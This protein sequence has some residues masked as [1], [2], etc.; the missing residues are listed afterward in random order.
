MLVRILVILIYMLAMG[1]ARA[2]SDVR[3]GCLPGSAGKTLAEVR[4]QPDAAWHPEN[5]IAPFHRLAKADWCRLR[6]S[7]PGPWGK[8]LRFK[9]TSAGLAPVATFYRPEAVRDEDG[10]MVGVERHSFGK[11]R[12]PAMLVKPQEYGRDFHV[13]FMTQNGPRGSLEAW[14]LSDYI[15][16]VRNEQSFD[17]AILASMAV[18]GVMAGL[19]AYQLGRRVLVFLGLWVLS[20]IALRFVESGLMTVWMPMEAGPRR[21]LNVVALTLA[22]VFSVVFSERYLGL[23][24]HFPKTSRL[25]LL[26]AVVMGGVGAM[27]AVQMSGA[28]RDIFNLLVIVQLV[29][30]GACA[31]I[32]F[33][34]GEEMARFFV[35]GWSP[36]LVATAV[37]A[38]YFL[39]DMPMPA[40]MDPA[41][42]LSLLFAV[43]VLLLV[44]A[45]ATRHAER[46]MHV[47]QRAA[48]HDALTGIPN[49]AHLFN[50]LNAGIA[51]SRLTGAPYALLFLDLDHFKRINDVYGHDV[52]DRCLQHFT[53]TMQARLRAGDTLARLGGEEFVILL[54]G[55][56]LEQAGEVSNDLSYSLAG[57]PLVLEDGIYQMTVS[58]GVAAL[59]ADDD[60]DSL[61]KRADAAVYR[62]KAEGRNRTV[63]ETALSAS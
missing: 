61:L 11:S 62:A 23:G 45:R 25:I 21:V 41:W 8:V 44:T 20:V 53:S 43:F 26:L 15:A 4:V 10:L 50:A 46:E 24:Q 58:V 3:V 34:R 14:Q 5:P 54:P 55:A 13:R 49:R 59:R 16:R 28:M 32:L 18:L 29:L 60:A 47:V 52:G 57:M 7:G 6:V 31:L 33:A 38:W 9:V 17:V 56:S 48:T 1:D 39:I 63:L 42:Q 36:V 35:L 19:F 2:A 51:K 30:V 27:T 12:H 22:V 37:R 40:W